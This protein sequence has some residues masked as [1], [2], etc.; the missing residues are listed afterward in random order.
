[1]IETPRTPSEAAASAHPGTPESSAPDLTGTPIP[2]GDPEVVA[3]RLIPPG[4]PPVA[5]A[6]LK[7]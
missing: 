5:P 3:R 4:K 6:P 1:M 7:I 2:V